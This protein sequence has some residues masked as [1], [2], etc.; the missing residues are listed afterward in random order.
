MSSVFYRTPRH[1]YPVAVAGLGAWVTDQAGR[2]YLDMSG[3]AAVSLLGHQQPDIVAAIQAQVGAL[4]Y[5]HTAFFTTNAQEQL[6]E[7]L[8][9]RF[10]DRA[11]RVYFSSG[12][13][14]ANETAIKM[15]WQY[16]AAKGRPEKQV[17]ISRENSYHG[18]T[19]LTLS[20]SGN[21]GRRKAAAAPLLDWP[22]LP[23]CYP[24]REQ[25]ASETVADYGARLAAELD[26]TLMA[27]G[28]DQVAAFICEPVIGASLGA[29]A[30]VPGYLAAVES[31]CRQ[32]GVLLIFDEVMAGSGRCGTYFAHEQDGARPDIVTLGKGIAA[33]YQPL[34]AT[35]IAG[36]IADTL[37]S[38]GFTHGHTYIGHP[39]AC[40]AGVAVQRQLDLGLIRDKGELMK[41]ALV[42][43][44][45]EASFVGDI[46][47][48]GLLLGLE[49][50]SD[51]TTKAG[52]SEP[53]ADR[54]RLEA[55][56]QGLIC[57]PGQFKTEAGFV[58][59]ILLAPP[60]I[61]TQDDIALCCDALALVFDKVLNVV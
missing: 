47:G 1:T 29:V 6:A 40:A 43:R 49:L 48:R 23:T 15:A 26:R 61:C 27:V 57:Y 18:N 33:G 60:A 36:D 25:R 5:A 56:A 21:V 7:M 58:P 10:N 4:A 46:R 9:T 17:I 24:Y 51:K 20:V 34:A 12:G 19:F 42:S 59:H 35:I 38:A 16:W 41:Q 32:H 28:A 52:F 2:R 3:G 37:A 45:G 22:R 39:V 14:E 8:V 11:S 30:P 50:V 44:F 13:S 31:V 55:M 53:L 54:L